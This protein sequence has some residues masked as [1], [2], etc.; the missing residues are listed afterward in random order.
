M[1]ER[2]SSDPRA[3][4]GASAPF[5]RLL[6]TTVCAGLLGKAALVASD[7]D[8]D[9]HRAKVVSA[10]FFGEQI[11]PTAVGLLAAVL[12]GD[13]DLYALDAAALV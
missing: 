9:F 8:D 7:H 6:G 3:L 4:L 10:R 12:A 11:L 2:S 1:I 13:D 5:L